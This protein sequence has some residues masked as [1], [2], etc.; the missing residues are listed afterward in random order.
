[1]NFFQ[2]SFFL[3]IFTFAVFCGSSFTVADDNNSKKGKKTLKC[4][5]SSKEFDIFYNDD[6]PQSITSTHKVA[7]R[8]SI[9]TAPL[10]D[11]YNTSKVVG[12]WTAREFNALRYSYDIQD[13]V[14]TYHFFDKKYPGGSSLIIM[15]SYFSLSEKN[16]YFLTSNINYSMKFL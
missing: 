13:Y 16:G 4:T 2:T 15:S 7:A 6:A 12:L 3:S 11:F 5:Y 8:T 10:R 14:A 9:L 1:M